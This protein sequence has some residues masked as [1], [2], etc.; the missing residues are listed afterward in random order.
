M[1]PLIPGIHAYIW[2]SQ[3]CVFFKP[4]YPLLQEATLPPL[5]NRFSI[6]Y[7]C[8]EHFCP[9]HGHWLSV[10]M[11]RDLS[12]IQTPI[13]T[14]E[15]NSARVIRSNEGEDNSVFLTALDAINA[16]NLDL[17]IL[18]QQALDQSDLH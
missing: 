17:R 9:S 2:I 13:L 6:C 16:P 10:E 11:H 15:T 3:I 12:T 7:Y 5:A 14:E 4:V 8:K 18:F 1:L